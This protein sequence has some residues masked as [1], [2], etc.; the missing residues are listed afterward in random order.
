M[1]SAV[2]RHQSKPRRRFYRYQHNHQTHM[3]RRLGCDLLFHLF[4]HFFKSAFE[5]HD[6]GNDLQPR[7]PGQ[8]HEILLENRSEKRLWECHRLCCLEFHYMQFACL[9]IQ[10][11][12]GQRGDGGHQHTDTDLGRGFRGDVLCRIFWNNRQSAIENHDNGNFI[13]P[14]H[15]SQEHN[16]LLEDRFEKRVRQRNRMHHLAFQDF[17]IGKRE[18]A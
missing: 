1:Q 12:P 3:V 15:I 18:T 2:L 11:K 9:R 17:A 13:Y 8:E 16:L 6:N 14:R 5:S 7:D 10:P 4:R